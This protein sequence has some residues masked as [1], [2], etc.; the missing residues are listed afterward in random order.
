MFGLSSYELPHSYEYDGEE[1][2]SWIGAGQTDSSIN[3][4]AATMV[5]MGVTKMS[6]HVV[7]VNQQQQRNKYFESINLLPSSPA[8]VPAVIRPGRPGSNPLPITSIPSYHHASPSPSVQPLRCCRSSS[9]PVEPC[10]LPRSS[11]IDIP[12]NNRRRSV[13]IMLYEQEIIDQYRSG[14][15]QSAKSTWDDIQEGGQEE[16]RTSGIVHDAD[17]DDLLFSASPSIHRLPHSYSIDFE[18]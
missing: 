14:S 10:P 3:T 2:E 8:V 16:L 1:G 9:Y 18:L 17:A 7:Q 11:P 6:H 12:L 5:M 4:K 15:C 13:G